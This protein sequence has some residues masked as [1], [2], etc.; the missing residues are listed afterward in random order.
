MIKNSIK[1]GFTLSEV[2]I[3]LV[4]IGVVA[5][6]TVP[7]IE[8]NTRVEQYRSSLF[9][10]LSTINQASLK[11]YD[12]YGE[13]PKCGYWKVNPYVASGNGAVCVERNEKGVCSRYQLKQGGDLPDDYNGFF[14]DC[15][16]LWR[17]YYDNLAIQKICKSEAYNTGCIPKYKGRD[18]LYSGTN[19]DKSEYEINQATSSSGFSQA[20]I[21]SGSAIVL[22][23]GSIIFSYMKESTRYFAVDVNGH[24]GPNKWGTD[25][26]AITPKMTSWTAVPVFEFDNSLK[27]TGGMSTNK[28]LYRR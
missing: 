6:I 13:N 15:T 17:S 25:V 26:Y 2:L 7:S 22:N 21:L 23:D 20:S 5:A 8:T 4:V 10:M 27:D 24:K 28:L 16:S 1:F 9:K 19:P 11:Y 12:I 3:T 18:T 14:E